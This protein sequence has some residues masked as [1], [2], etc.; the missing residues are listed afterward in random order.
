M[1]T[2]LHQLM[3]EHLAEIGI[4]NLIFAPI[5]KGSDTVTKPNDNVIVSPCFTKADRCSFDYKQKKILR[6][7]QEAIDIDKTDVI[8][9]Y[10]LFTDGNCAMKLSEK[11]GVPY[12]VAVRDTDVNYFF[13]YRP[14]LIGRGAK[15]MRNASAVFFL[16]DSY[17]NRVLNDFVPVEYREEIS[18]KT[19]IVPNGIDPFW[20]NNT[21]TER[22]AQ[23]S[24][25]R[26]ENRI[27]KVICVAQIC[28]RKN[29]PT[30][31]DALNKLKEKGWKPELT[32]IGK[33]ADKALLER[34]CSD[35]NTIYLDKMP[36]EEL[37]DYYRAADI[38]VLPSK[39]ETFGLV[40]A[41]AT[42]QG[43]PILYSKGQGFDGQFEEG[44]VGYHIDALNPDDICEK[45]ERV[46][47]EYKKLSDECIKSA[48][49]FD[50]SDIC[51]EYKSIYEE[52]LNSK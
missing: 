42:T 47:A 30:L 21:Y 45:L 11:Y 6:A 15:I 23:I 10:T 27:V 25:K 9:A 40:Y 29:I 26:M 43:L 22:D 3:A 20:I 24:L 48:G 16:S 12:V 44:K 34:I 33:A 46:A 13:K 17:K 8:H 19:H 4:D 49:R 28:Q 7:A 18:S 5:C 51:G 52:I 35:E 41:E 36:K 38:F 50:W 14:W 32:V 37:I 39:T 2:P 1:G 31:Q